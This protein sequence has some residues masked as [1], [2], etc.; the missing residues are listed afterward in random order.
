MKAFRHN[1]FFREIVHD[2]RGLGKAL[3]KLT[4]AQDMVLYN[5]AKLR[6]N[7]QLFVFLGETVWYETCLHHGVPNRKAIE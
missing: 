6:L 5:V 3:G 2:K 7:N 1:I 4:M